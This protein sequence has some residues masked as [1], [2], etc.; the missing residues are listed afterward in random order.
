MPLLLRRRGQ[1]KYLIFRRIFYG[2]LA[3]SNDKLRRTPL[4]LLFCWVTISMLTLFV[5]L[6]LDC[7]NF[8]E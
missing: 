8:F 6:P 5:L 2:L 4:L 7:D 1:G 3:F